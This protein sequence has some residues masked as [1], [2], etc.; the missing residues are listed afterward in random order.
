MGWFVLLPYE[1]KS[2]ARHAAGGSLLTNFLLRASTDLA[3]AAE[4]KPLLHLWSLGIEEPFYLAFP[5]LLWF[6]KPA[7]GS[8]RGHC[9][10]RHGVAGLPNLRSPRLPQLAFYYPQARFWELLTR[11]HCWPTPR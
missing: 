4:T 2:L 10:G 3:E 1:L 9:G 6:M 5:L 11:W 8:V 7:A